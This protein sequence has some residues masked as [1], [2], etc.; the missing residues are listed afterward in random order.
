MPDAPEP[1]NP[2]T[3]NAEMGEAIFTQI[4]SIYVNP[5]IARRV[6]AG[7]MAAGTTLTKIQV[8]LFDD[9]RNQVRLNEEVKATWKVKL[10]KGVRK[11]K[12]DPIYDNEVE[13]FQPAELLDDDLD[14]AHVTMISVAD[15]WQISFSF[16]YNQKTA[17]AHLEAAEE[18][19]ASAKESMANGRFRPFVD[20]LFSS[21]ELA[22]KAL[23]LSL[24]MDGIK[25]SRRH[26]NL[27]SN[28][29][30]LGHSGMVPEELT[31]AFNTLDKGRYPARY[32]DANFNLTAADAQKL[33]DA[34][35]GIIDHAK[36]RII[37]TVVNDPTT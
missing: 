2:K 22:V 21:S 7:L 26:S 9:G 30:R 16:Q 20:N 8:I 23:L 18:F 19:F 14:C 27:H 33:L 25:A 29:N 37:P 6:E 28:Y 1:E 31:A 36:A 5:E 34:V 10:K 17:R 4:I 15:R 35:R 13:Q 32:L 12:G 24:P 11:E 3:E